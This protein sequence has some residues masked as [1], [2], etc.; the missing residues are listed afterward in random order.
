MVEDGTVGAYCIRPFDGSTRLTPTTQEYIWTPDKS[1]PSGVY[2]VR[3]R[4]GDC[5]MARRVV[6]LK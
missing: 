4:I 6:Y 2:L 3:V 1:L 5:E